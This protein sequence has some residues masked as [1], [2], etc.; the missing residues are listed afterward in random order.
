MIYNAFQLVE[1]CAL[2]PPQRDLVALYKSGE[3]EPDAYKIRAYIERQ[4]K[5]DCKNLA[6][7]LSLQLVNRLERIF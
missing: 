2:M 1:T 5:P 4:T 6:A 3:P 7:R